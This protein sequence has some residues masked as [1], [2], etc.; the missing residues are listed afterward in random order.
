[1]SSVTTSLLVFGIYL[2]VGGL[3]FAF[4]PNMGL[5]MFALPPTTEPWIRVVG[6]LI[7]VIGYYYV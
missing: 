6:T 3:G 2:I 7:L 5:G 1:M 4:A